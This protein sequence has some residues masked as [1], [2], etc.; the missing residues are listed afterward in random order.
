MKTSFVLFLSLISILSAQQQLQIVAVTPT[1]ILSSVDQADAIAVTFSEPMVPLQSSGIPAS[2]N[3]MSI[4]PKT[5]GTFRWQGT[6]T[7]TF[8]PKKPLDVATVYAV[9]ITQGAKAVSGRTLSEQFEWRFTT[10]LL[11]VLAVSPAEGETYVEADHSIMIQFNQ[12]IKPFD[13]AKSVS[14]QI[15][16]NGTVMHPAFSTLWNGKGDTDRIYIKT[17]NPMPLDAKVTVTVKQG[18]KG[19]I[20][21]L[22][23]L[24]PFTAS[25]STA[26]TFSFLGLAGGNTIT[27][28]NPVRLRFSN[29]VFEQDLFEHLRFVPDA[30]V[31]DQGYF[32]SYPNNEW[33]MN[34]ELLPDQP[35]RG[36]ILPGMKDRFGQVLKDTVWF[37]FMSSAYDAYFDMPTGIGLLEAYEHRRI[38]ITTVNVERF[39]LR[40]GKI[41]PEQLIPLRRRFQS[42]GQINIMNGGKLV[43]SSAVTENERLFTFRNSV[44]P[45]AARN[46]VG[47]FYAGLDTVLGS[48]RTGTALVL[49][50]DGTSFYQTLVNVSHMGVTAKFS[51]DD[52]L[53]WVTGL[54]DAAPVSNAAVEIRSDDNA[55][56]WKG[57]TSPDGSVK[58]PGW[59]KLGLGT[60]WTS[61]EYDPDEEF[62]VEK[63]LIWIF[64]RKAN[65]FAYIS[66]NDGSGIEPWSFDINYEWRPSFERI[67][68]SVFTDRGLYKAGERVDLKGVVRSLKNGTWNIIAGDSVRFTVKNSRGEIVFVHAAALSSFASAHASFTLSGNAPLGYYWMTLEVK[69][70]SKKG[71]SWLTVGGDN[72]RVEAFRAAEFDVTTVMQKQSYISGDSVSGAISARY[73]FGAPLKNAPVRWRMTV[74]GDSYTPPGYEGYYFEPLYWLTRYDRSQYRELENGEDVLDEYGNLSVA[75]KVNVGEIGMTSLLM[76]EA[77]ATSSSRQ[78]ISG[79][80]SVTVHNGE[81]YLGIGQQT[82]FVKAD[83]AMKFKLIAVSPEGKAVPGVEMTFRVV[84]RIWNSIRRAGVGGRYYWESSVENIQADT[85][86]VTSKE[87]PAEYVFTPKAPGFYYTELRGTDPR[88]NEIV[89]NSYFYV[90][91]PGYVPWERSD[92]DRIDLITDRSNYAPGDVARIIVKNPYESAIALVTVE[93]EGIMHHFTT[94]VNGSAPQLE[95]PIK[96][97]YLP[98]VY[99]SVVLLQGRVDSIAATKL[100]DI[101]RPSF[102]IG[103]CK[104]SVSPL[105]K[106]LTVKLSTTKNDYRPGDTVTVSIST[107]LQSGKPVSSEVVLS[108]A[109]LGVLNL[110]GYRLPA[111]FDTYYRERGLAVST[112]ETRAH[113]IEQR[114]FGEKAE[115]VGGGGADKMSAQVDADGVRKDFRPSAYWNPSIITDAKGSAVIKFKLPDNLTAFQLMAVAHTAGSE[116]GYGEHSITVSK[117]LLLQPSFPRFVR[118]GDTFEGGVV[119]VNFSEKVKKVKLVSSISGVTTADA[120]T[121][122]HLLQPGESKEIRLRYTAEKLGTAK[123]IFRAYT[124]D[125]Y[126]GMQWTIP[127]QV[128][129]L[130]ETAASSNTLTEK[131]ITEMIAAPKDIFRDLG[132]FDVTVSSTQMVGLQNSVQYLFE[133]P[134]GC[135]EQK[136][137]RALPI[138]IGAELVK[139]FDLEVLKG[140]DLRAVAQDVL[141]EVPQYQQPNGGFS[142]W[143]NSYDSDPFPYLSAYTMYGLTLASQKKYRVDR[144]SMEEGMSYLREVLNA[145]QTAR[146][147]E[148]VDLSTKALIVYVL[149]LN[150]K[151]DFG[152]MEKL[153]ER[154]EGMP[155]FARAYLLKAL[156]RSGGNVTMIRTLAEGIM[157]G[158]KISPTTAHFE[159]QSGDDWWWM[160]HSNVRTTALAVDAL[161][162]VEPKN[163]LIPKAVRWL[164][165]RQQ[166]GFWRTTQ[167]NLY[168]IQALAS[169]FSVYE[170]IEPKF[171]AVLMLAGRTVM[172]EAFAGRTLKTALSA[173]PIS[174]L[175][176]APAPLIVTKNGEG[177]LYYTMRL[178]Y[179][180]RVQSET[181]DAG[182]SV[183]KSVEHLLP[184]GKDSMAIGINQLAK[185][186]LTVTT[187]QDRPFVVVD[188]PV[189]AGF[190]IVNTSFKT[191][192][193][194]LDDDNGRNWYFNHT[195]QRDDRALFFADYLP[196]GIHTITYLVRVT[197]YGTFQMPATKVEQMY[198]PEVYGQTSSAIVTVQ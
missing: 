112:S 43:R 10:P 102:K 188:D 59:G 65:D 79:R 23:M 2:V 189:P 122:I 6:S 144:T 194:N 103:Y 18:V 92:D 100:A 137:S 96:K 141:D 118:A 135:L 162:E 34:V 155:L 53:V 193:Q 126:D 166:N 3:Y 49:S 77:D 41:D 80:T 147:S 139:A 105:E 104:L 72:F 101:G 198:E 9:T 186:T 184:V 196:A 133:Y 90:T 84:Q 115:E 98:N 157:N 48:S 37:N 124:E 86:H 114:N 57:V 149:A 46:S 117:P 27:P 36:M 178:S 154:R 56:L 33:Y 13:V 16:A 40:M 140:K 5:E 8:I 35:Y 181:K 197:S 145:P 64:V 159:E 116:F 82:T 7:L 190:E 21:Q 176:E 110:I 11:R 172:N 132:S 76:L 108:V 161:M 179:Y 191:T 152:H 4:S 28:G 14:V 44:K 25:F 19:T 91:G 88:G 143:K 69:E 142:Y 22:G 146:Y 51:P 120:E 30:E 165:D 151:A 73:L 83:S 89:S 192:G 42:N 52:I 174:E 170:N 160:F 167:E 136:M 99:I 74:T 20:G 195:E 180:P 123:F 163:E 171:K 183:A 182:F 127:V 71:Q 60:G 29:P 32:S 45:K 106:K 55:V 164:L 85:A 58:A 93:R 175:S 148:G 47:F 50:E 158:V 81:F 1:G 169:Y 97:E 168:V 125:D 62:R 138:I 107:Q 70:K 177:R 156:Q 111:L 109:D 24:S 68:G 31:T 54:K 119:A 131:S 121:S 38:P 67:Q 113:L 66:S 153:F 150:G 61:D 185:V 187:R 94:H 128:P 78:V 12:R 26:N 130:C 173:T 75:S 87:Q 17:V 134:Y 15:A 63:P 129:R 95:I 39:T